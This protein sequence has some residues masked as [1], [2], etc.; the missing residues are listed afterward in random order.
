MTARPPSPRRAPV[1][2]WSTKALAFYGRRGQGAQDVIHR[3]LLM[4]LGAD[5][6]LDTQGRIVSDT[7]RRVT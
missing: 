1:D 6:H 3:A 7:G 2:E 4:L 5:G